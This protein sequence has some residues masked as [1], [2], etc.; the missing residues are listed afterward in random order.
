MDALNQQGLTPLKKCTEAIRQLANGSAT[1]HLDEH[2]KIGE[3]T[4]IECMKNIV[5][6]VITVFGGHYLRHPTVDD[7]E[8][9]LKIGESRSFPSIFGSIDCMD[10]Q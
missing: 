5:D 6:G 4:A 9:L 2:L 7:V 1:D 3:T 8:R 10:W